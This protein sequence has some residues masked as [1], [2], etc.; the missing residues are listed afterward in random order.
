MTVPAVESFRMVDSS[1]I[2]P[3]KG[4][5][6]SLFRTCRAPGNVAARFNSVQCVWNPSLCSN[7]TMA[8]ISE[9]EF[10]RIVDGIDQDRTVILTHNPIGSP[11]ETLLWMLMSCLVSYLSLEGGE[12]PCFT[13]RP[14]ARTYREAI[15]FILRGRKADG[16]DESVYLD[17]LTRE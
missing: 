11:S 8:S 3:E 6:L 2:P 7:I 10:R 4:G 12:T 1:N 5:A 15:I 14:D 17:K 13:G 16:F 9:A